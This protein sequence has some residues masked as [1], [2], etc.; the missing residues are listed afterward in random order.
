MNPSRENHAEV[1]GSFTPCREGISPGS[2]PKILGI[3]FT[4]IGYDDVLTT[5]AS[6]QRWGERHYITLTPPHSV[7]L[8]RRD[9]QLRQATNQA[10]LIL[11]DGTGIILAARLL[12][13]PMS[14]SLM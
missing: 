2:G 5:I 10:G 9:H 12:G 13:Y 14:K 11:P 7:I 8:C 3:S 6:W 1:G 4:L